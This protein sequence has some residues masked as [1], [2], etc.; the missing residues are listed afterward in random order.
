MIAL[1]TADNLG[2]GFAPCDFACGEAGAPN[3]DV[4]SVIALVVMT[5]LDGTEPVMA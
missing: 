4:W 2:G 5:V 3:A 1:I